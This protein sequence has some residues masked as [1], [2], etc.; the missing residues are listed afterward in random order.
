MK[1]RFSLALLPVVHRSSKY[2]LL[3]TDRFSRR[4]DKVVATGAGF[5]AGRT[6]NILSRRYIFRV[7]YLCSRYCRGK[8]LQPFP[9]IS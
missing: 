9:I 1:C 8:C 6:A 2:L 5:T 7:V 4:A 3:L